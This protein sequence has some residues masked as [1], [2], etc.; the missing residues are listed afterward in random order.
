MITAKDI[1][2]GITQ[3]DPN[4]IGLEVLLKTFA[5]NR[6]LELCVPIVYGSLS[7]L[8]AHQKEIHADSL[9]FNMISEADQAKHNHPNFLPVGNKDFVPTIGEGNRA[10]GA[11]ALAALEK[12]VEDV[13]S[14][15]I[16]VL[17]T[18]PINKDF[19][20]SED[21]KF[22]GHTEYL[23]MKDGKGSSLMFLVSDRVRVAVATGHI[24][25]S[26]VSGRLTKEL[27]VQKVNEIEASLKQDFSISKPKIAVLGLNPH[28]GDNGLL[29]KEDVEVIKP[30]VEQLKEEGKLVFGPLSSDGFFGSGSY[31]QYDAVLAMYH[32]QGLIPFKTLAFGSGTNF[33]AG[34]SFI[35][36]SPDHGTGYDIV[37]KGVADESSM[38]QAIFAAIDIFKNRSLNEEL[39]SNQLLV[40]KHR[41]E[42][43]WVQ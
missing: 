24:P 11:E 31:R 38:R 25:V 34:L 42:R 39:T 30:V 35:R 6:M 10:G 2:V 28:A 7:A 17:V 37:G 9:Q 43:S 41:K 14:G 33:T 13:K 18:A 36:T 20:Q 27:L 26:E 22:P 32:D 29:G 12:A 40:K 15:V 4:G 3:G 16:D 5:D 21:F 19:I 1:K 8:K 23:A